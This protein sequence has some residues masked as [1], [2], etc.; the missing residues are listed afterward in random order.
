[1][2]SE[3]A[4]VK[5]GIT[6]ESVLGSVVFLSHNN[7]ISSSVIQISLCILLMMLI[8]TLYSCIVD[9]V[10]VKLYVLLC[11]SYNCL[12]SGFHTIN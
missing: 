2:A 3:Y 11:I 4:H 9:L 10:P 5:T 7:D 6:Q 8:C 12:V 1:M